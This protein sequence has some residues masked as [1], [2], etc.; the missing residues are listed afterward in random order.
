MQLYEKSLSEAPQAYHKSLL[1]DDVKVWREVSDFLGLTKQGENPE[2]HKDL[3]ILLSEA[4]GKLDGKSPSTYMVI[5]AA[6]SEDTILLATRLIISKIDQAL[7][8][9]DRDSA[10]KAKAILKKLNPSSAY[11]TDCLLGYLPQDKLYDDGA[12]DLH[13]DSNKL[14]IG[15][16][17][18][19]DYANREVEKQNIGVAGAVAVF[20]LVLTLADSIRTMIVDHQRRTEDLMRDDRKNKQDELLAKQSLYNDC[21]HGPAVC[22]KLYPEAAAAVKKAVADVKADADKNAGTAG[23]GRRV[24]PDSVVTPSRPSTKPCVGCG[25]SGGEVYVPE[26]DLDTTRFGSGIANPGR[27]TRF[28]ETAADRLCE[29]VESNFNVYMSNKVSGPRRVEDNSAYEVSLEI[30]QSCEVVEF[31]KW[32]PEFFQDQKIQK[33]MDVTSTASHC[34]AADPVK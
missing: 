26:G 20:T 34:Q 4:A 28:D 22:D 12:K 7:A 18:G 2:E 30:P 31:E 6:I 19:I 33:L 13:P 21:K 16:L 23:P 24:E 10:D 27:F 32:T 29:K 5:S 9:H 11:A 1:Y 3:T 14:R 8:N 15:P 25:G 17:S